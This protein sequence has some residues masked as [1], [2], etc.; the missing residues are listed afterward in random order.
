MP[1]GTVIKLK[2]LEDKIKEDSGLVATWPTPTASQLGGQAT[3]KKVIDFE[4]AG[5][6]VLIARGGRGGRGEM[7]I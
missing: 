4:K 5:M 3:E 1:L 6:K 2:K 7:F